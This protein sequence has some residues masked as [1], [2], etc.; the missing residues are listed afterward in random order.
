MVE[1]AQVEGKENEC[2]EE[3]LNDFNQEVESVV[4]L[5]L[6]AEEEAE[7]K[8]ENEN[9][10]ECLSIVRQVAEDDEVVALKLAAEEAREQAGKVINPWQM[11][12]KMLEDWLNNPGPVRELTEFELSGRMTKQ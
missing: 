4:A 3:Q 5:E 7:M 12:L 1:T 9:S 11:E 10:E 8:E 2:S 6:T